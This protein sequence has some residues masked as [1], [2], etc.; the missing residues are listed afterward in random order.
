MEVFQSVISFLGDLPELVAL[1]SCP[2][3]LVAVGLLLSIFHAQKAYLPVA[4]G[5][6]GVGYALMYCQDSAA[7]PVWLGFYVLLCVIV[8]LLFLIPFPRWRG[9][10]EIGDELYEKFHVPLDEPFPPEEEQDGLETYDKEECGLRLA[11]ANALIEK[12]LKGDLEASDR[13]EVDAISRTISGYGE[14]ELTADEMRSL[15]DCL[16]TVL[17]LTAKYK[18]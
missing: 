4:I 13:L 6:G 17:K 16:A 7:A 5:L 2:V 15:N 14:R 3:L 11:H 8:R 1:I 12:L 18:L 9:D 10:K